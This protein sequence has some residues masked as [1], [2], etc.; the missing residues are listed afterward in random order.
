MRV[1]CEIADPLADLDAR[2]N[3]VRQVAELSH[4]KVVSEG[5]NVV[6]VEIP[7]DIAVGLARLWGERRL[8]ADL[9]RTDNAPGG[10]AYH[11]RRKDRLRRRH[12]HHAVLSL[13]HRSHARHARGL[14]HHV[15]GARSRT[16]QHICQEQKPIRLGPRVT[17][18]SRGPSEISGVG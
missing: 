10:A 15:D 8:P 9:R 7:A 16:V 17:A 11:G 5:D 4:G 3:R 14:G 1:D 6:V 12:G 2:A 18:V 13:S